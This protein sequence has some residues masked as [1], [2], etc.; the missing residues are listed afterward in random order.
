MIGARYR[1][2]EHIREHLLKAARW[3]TFSSTPIAERF[4]DWT[5]PSSKPR[6]YPRRAQRRHS[7]HTNL[8]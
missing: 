4:F 3:T 2:E 5:N 7:T 6:V 1:V 8:L